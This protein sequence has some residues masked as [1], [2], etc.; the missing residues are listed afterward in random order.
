MKYFLVFA[1]LLSTIIL[2][3]SYGDSAFASHMGSHHD[4][5]G[6]MMDKGMMMSGNHHH[7][8]SYHGMCAPGFTSLDTMCVLDDRCGPG[9]YPGK[10]CMM[11]GDMKPYLRPLQQKHAGI[12]VDHIICAE[13]K[14]IMFK[15]HNASPSCVN[16]NSVNELQN[17]GWQTEKPAIACTLDYSPV[18]G[19][20]GMTYG[21][22]CGLT[23][24]HMALHHQG[25][26]MDLPESTISNFEECVAAGNPVME[27]HPRQCRTV[28]GAHFVEEIE[29]EKQEEY[30]R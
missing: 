25:E 30:Y 11:D 19:V 14:Q 1:I 8:M 4:N 2:V 20:D 26:C 28:D 23:S 9:A 6:K 7:H 16:P 17:R 21:N 3:S 10:I 12:S 24:Q 22:M 18:C 29:I 27:S 5:D 15:H 13:G